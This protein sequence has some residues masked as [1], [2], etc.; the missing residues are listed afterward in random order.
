MAH[1][2]HSIN[3]TVSGSCDHAD[4]VADEEHHRYA[5]DALSYQAQCCFATGL[6]PNASLGS[7]PENVIRYEVDTLA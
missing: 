2:I 1:V 7:R 6:R 4:A 5:L 3:I